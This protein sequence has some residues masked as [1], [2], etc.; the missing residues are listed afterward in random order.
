MKL[1]ME[2]WRGFLNENVDNIDDKI[3]AALS[4]LPLPAPEEPDN[5]DPQ[6]EYDLDAW[7]LDNNAWDDWSRALADA[8][9]K[10]KA[11]GFDADKD[12]GGYAEYDKKYFP[13]Q[14][15]MSLGWSDPD[16]RMWSFA[17]EGK[18]VGELTES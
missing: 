6:Y 5:E 4:D 3:L 16:N 14:L 17:L 8:M 13:R 7:E 9:A 18:R 11:L 1:I 12:E 10:L 15:T 2:N